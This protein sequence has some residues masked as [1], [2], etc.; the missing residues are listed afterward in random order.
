MQVNSLSKTFNLFLTGSFFVFCLVFFNQLYDLHILDKYVKLAPTDKSTGFQV[1]FG[2]ISISVLIFLGMVIEAITDVI[3]EKVRYAIRHMSIQ[4]KISSIFLQIDNYEQYKYWKDKF[5][6]EVKESSNQSIS[7]IIAK[8]RVYISTPI[9]FGYGP[10]H[11][12]DWVARHY[13]TYLLATNFNILIVFFMLFLT[14]K[15]GVNMSILLLGGCLLYLNTILAIDKYFYSY[16][17]LYR[18]G[19]LYLSN[20]DT[21]KS[22]EEEVSKSKEEEIQLKA[23]I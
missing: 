20:L 16:S 10:N 19:I 9:V 2:L 14:C 15:I 17:L 7:S 6:S 22:K 1:V 23:N 3:R 13:S 4:Q 12:A 11:F 5:T 18:Y 8:E 21:N